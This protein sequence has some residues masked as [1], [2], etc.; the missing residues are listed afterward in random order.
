MAAPQS[1]T[2]RMPP[3]L[4]FPCA[5]LSDEDIAKRDATSLIPSPFF[6]SLAAVWADPR[7]TAVTR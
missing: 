6:S 2:H 4:G 1:G 3:L 7:Q 5:P